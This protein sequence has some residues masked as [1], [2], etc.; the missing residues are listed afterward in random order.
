MSHLRCHIRDYLAL[1]RALG[2]KLEKEGRLC[3][4]SPPSPKPPA[5]R[6]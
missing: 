1:R 2:F 3:R 5:R 4:T 6:R